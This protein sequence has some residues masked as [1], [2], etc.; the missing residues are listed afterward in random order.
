MFEHI[1]SIAT[2]ILNVSH[3]FYKLLFL[4]D[5]FTTHHNHTSLT[6]DVESFNSLT[7]IPLIQEPPIL[8]LDKLEHARYSFPCNSPLRLLAI[9]I[10]VGENETISLSELGL[11]FESS[12][13]LAHSHRT[14]KTNRALVCSR[15]THA[16]YSERVV[17]F[18]E[19]G[20]HLFQTNFSETSNSLTH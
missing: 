11:A 3:R 8:G 10:P 6:T 15:Q 13:S 1:F 7:T 20:G 2:Y 17:S 9:F 18:S 12:I 4:T 5:H 14:R 19:N 16:R